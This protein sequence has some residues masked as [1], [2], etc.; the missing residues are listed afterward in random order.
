VYSSLESSRAAKRSGSRSAGLLV[1]G[2][3]EA[4]RERE[5]EE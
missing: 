5:E 1:N 3:E 4:G 2:G